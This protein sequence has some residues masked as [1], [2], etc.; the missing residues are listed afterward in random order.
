MACFAERGYAKASNRAIAQRAGVTGA[1]LY[2]YF[3]SK[4]ALFWSAL[5][6]VD[7]RLVAIYRAASAAAPDEPSMRQ[8]SLGLERVIEL[9][10]ARPELMRFAANAEGEIARHPEL[11][12]YRDAGDESFA[13]LFRD[14]VQRART[15]GE[16]DRSV[17][18]EAAVKVLQACFTALALLHG[19]CRDTDEFAAVL[20]T[21]EHLI[22]GDFMLARS[23]PAAAR[24][25]L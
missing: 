15:R 23:G 24:P 25:R 17:D 4:A 16:L 10:R 9:T 14:L 22:V 8:L 1:L 2:H 13:V 21:F 7:A 18:V 11:R 6:E 20:R 5:L 3:D 19:A 12:A